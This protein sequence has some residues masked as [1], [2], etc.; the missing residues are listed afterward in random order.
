MTTTGPGTSGSIHDDVAVEIEQ[1]QDLVAETTSET[2]SVVT[3]ASDVTAEPTDIDATTLSDVKRPRESN[4][5]NSSP[6]EKSTICT[7]MC[8]NE[9]GV[10]EHGKECYGKIPFQSKKSNKKCFLKVGDCGMIIYHLYVLNMI[11]RLVYFDFESIKL[12]FTYC[13]GFFSFFFFFFF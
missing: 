3:E 2:I 4:V 10:D 7:E 11:V 5:N 8:E 12:F 9:K 13:F 1:T 6:N